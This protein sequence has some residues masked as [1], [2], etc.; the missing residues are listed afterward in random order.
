MDQSDII[1]AYTRADA[2]RDG[3]LIDVSTVRPE[4]LANAGIS[5]PVAL[6]DTV[7][8]E[9]VAVPK[10]VD[11]QDETGRLWDILWM[12]RCAVL[13]QHS[14]SDTMR[15]RLFVR[16]D[17]VRPREIELKAMIHPGDPGQPV[18][19]TIMRPEED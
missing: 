8:N 12:F 10:G 4:L 3:V 17:N 7:W 19:I 11:G 1:F 9:Y 18:V 6:T 14:E 15:F 2:I 16:N 13:A 5:I